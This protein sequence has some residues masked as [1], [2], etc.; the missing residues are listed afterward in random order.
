MEIMRLAAEYYHGRLSSDKYKFAYEFLRI[1]RG[2]NPRTIKNHLLGWSDGTACNMLLNSGYTH[3]ELIASGIMDKTGRDALRNVITIAYQLNGNV[4]DIRAKDIAGKYK[5]LPGHSG[6]PYNI[7]S[8]QGETVVVVCEG[9]FDALV[10]EQLGYASIGV[11]G[12]TNWQESWNSYL[13]NVKKVYIVFDADKAGVEG[14]EKTA[15]K[16]GSKARIVSLPDDVPG[17]DLSDWIVVHGHLK[18]EFDMLLA[19]ARGGILVTAEE[20]Y[21]DWMENEGNPDRTG[22]KF[23]LPHL[24]EVITPGFLPGQVMIILAKTGGRKNSCWFEFVS[25]YDRREAGH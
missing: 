23:G 13:S 24:D 21:Q 10:A 11:P 9:E 22:L 12:S 14:A 18:E 2:L 3:D 16:I 8:V 5:T 6:R 20:A 4:V 7:D 25:S 15:D 1:K 17:V 19:E